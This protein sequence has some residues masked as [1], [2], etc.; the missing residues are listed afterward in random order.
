MDTAAPRDA[1]SSA[2]PTPILDRLAPMP[3]PER[4]RASPLTILLLACAALVVLAFSPRLP[5]WQAVAQS[6]SD[7]FASFGDMPA[8]EFLIILLAA[9]FLAIAVHELGHALVGAVVGFRVHSIRIARL[10]IEPPFRLSLYRGSRSGARGWVALSPGRTDRLAMRTAVMAAAGPAANLL[11]WALAAALPIATG[12][13]LSVFAFISL[14]L[15]LVNLLPIRSGPAVSDGRRLLMILAN[16]ARGE[17]WLALMK[18]TADLVDGVAPEFFSPEYIAIA[19]AVTDKTS[20]TVNAHALA[21]A[22]AFQQRK[23]EEAARLLEVTLEYSAYAPPALRHALVTDAVLFQARRRRR[24]DLAE[25]WRSELPAGTEIPWLGMLADAALLDARGDR[26]GALRTLDAVE[27]RI[28]K[29]PSAVQRRIS[30][31]SLNRWRAELGSVPP[32]PPRAP[33]T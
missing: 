24:V 1:G 4:T 18:L 26:G 13:F 17:R 7:A 11:S 22:A 25:A 10:Q 6:L 23:D 14:G 21:Y 32:F 5:G 15:G 3:T 30:L 9:L 20:D 16:R 19:T 12:G 31:Q 2:S 8:V 28:M 27:A 33:I 29:A